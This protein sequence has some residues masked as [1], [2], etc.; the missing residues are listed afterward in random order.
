LSAARKQQEITMA[1][2]GTALSD[3]FTVS[4]HDKNIDTLTGSN[5]ENLMI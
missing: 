2:I 3:P 1:L 5:S 4:W